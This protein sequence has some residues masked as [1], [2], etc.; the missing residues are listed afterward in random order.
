MRNEGI[1]YE[2]YGIN[3]EFS[4]MKIENPETEVL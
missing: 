4:R 3:N 2:A 1:L